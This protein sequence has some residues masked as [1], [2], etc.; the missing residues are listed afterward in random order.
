MNLIPYEMEFGFRS[1]K[2][3]FRSTKFDSRSTKFGSLSTTFNSISISKFHFGSTNIELYINHEIR[4][5]SKL[6]NLNSMRTLFYC[7][8]LHLI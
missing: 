6:V 3:D 8:V 5:I 7:K 1:T 2:F 4:I